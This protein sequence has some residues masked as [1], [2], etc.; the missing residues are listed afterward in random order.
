MLINTYYSGWKTALSAGRSQDLLELGNDMVEYYE[1]YFGN[2]FRVWKDGYYTVQAL[3]PL[4][5]VAPYITTM[6]TEK[7]NHFRYFCTSRKGNRKYVTQKLMAIVLSGTLIFALSELL[8]A[9]LTYLKTAHDT[10]LE[11]IQD[12]VSYR[13]DCFISNP[14]R[15]FGMIYI[16]HVVYYLCFL[17][18]AVGITSFIKNRIA[19]VIV[20]FIVTSLLD[21]GLPTELQPY[22]VMRPYYFSF[23]LK[24]YII[25]NLLYVLV[26]IA[27]LIISEISYARKGN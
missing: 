5:L 4:F 24:G 19:V 10:E 12:I 17:I 9:G 1:K 8:F 26:G 27:V 2:V 7:N 18:F 20:P 15:Y 13:A 25:L 6:L 3:T 11:Y 22:V 16:L 23:S 14:F 21:M